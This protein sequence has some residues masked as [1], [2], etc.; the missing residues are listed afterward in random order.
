M[1]LSIIPVT[2]IPWFHGFPI[3][4][5]WTC[6]CGFY[7]TEL[8]IFCLIHLLLV[9]VAVAI[10]VESLVPSDPPQPPDQAVCRVIFRAIDNH[11][12]QPVFQ[13][14]LKSKL[15]YLFPCRSIQLYNFSF[16]PRVLTWGLACHDNDT[17][18]TTDF[19]FFVYFY[20]LQQLCSIHLEPINIFQLNKV[21]EHIWKL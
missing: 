11:L 9:Q 19:V 3:G 18:I 16:S 20:F 6:S 7:D 13:F 14:F 17:I 4:L 1:L 10:A 15:L 8:I 5:L 12:L 21:F 2:I